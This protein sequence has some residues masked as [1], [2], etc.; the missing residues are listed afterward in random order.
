MN[1]FSAEIGF[2]LGKADQ[3]KKAYDCP[4]DIDLIP[5]PRELRRCRKCMMI[6]VQ[7]FTPD[8]ESPREDICTPSDVVE[9]FLCSPA[10]FDW[11]EITIDPVLVEDL[12]TPN[13]TPRPVADTIDD[14]GRMDRDPEDIDPPEDQTLPPKEE[15]VGTQEEHK[16]DHGMPWVE[17]A[18]YPVIFAALSIIL[19]RFGVDSLLFVVPNSEE[20]HLPQSFLDGTVWVIYRLH[21]GMVFA[22]SSCP[23]SFHYSCGYPEPKTED[24]SDHWTEIQSAV[25]HRAMKVDRHTHDR[26][27]GSTNRDPEEAPSREHCISTKPVVHD[28]PP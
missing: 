18:L 4:S 24:M 12:D 22:V 15:E 21:F 14:A 3:S 23:L 26:K 10:M 11:N 6:C 8:P 25:S 28:A 2:Q 20:E 27:L 1:R 16:P 5:V 17:I 7:F 13:W 19:E 9:S